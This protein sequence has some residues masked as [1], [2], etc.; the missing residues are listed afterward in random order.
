MLDDKDIQKLLEAMESKFPT[1]GEFEIS[2]KEISQ[3]LDGL[4]EMVQSLVVSVDKLVGAVG[5]LH[6][7]Y[8]MVASK[9]DRHEKWIQKLAEKLP[10]ADASCYAIVNGLLNGNVLGSG[11]LSGDGIL[12]E[13]NYALRLSHYLSILKRLPIQLEAH[14]P[15]QLIYLMFLIE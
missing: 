7:E 5:D 10:L 4:R 13:Q 1:R 12:T 11:S 14:G 9:I 6:Q 8:T 2:K 15:R 3:D